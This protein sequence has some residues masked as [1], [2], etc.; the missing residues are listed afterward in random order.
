[1]LIRTARVLALIGALAA[2]AISV[3]PTP[4]GAQEPPPDD[5][6]NILVVVTDDQRVDTMSIMRHTRDLLTERGT[7][8]SHAYA[9]TPLCCPSRS[10]IFSG[11]YVHNHGVDTNGGSG[12]LDQTTTMQAHLQGAGYYTAMAGKFLNGWPVY[13]RPPYFNRYALRQ[14]GSVYTD[15]VWNIQ[16]NIRVRPDYDTQLLGKHTVAFLERFDKRNDERPWFM[17]VAPIAPHLPADPE[18]KY[19]DAYVP[20]WPDTPAMHEEDLSDK[21]L[22]VQESN[23]RADRDIRRVIRKQFRSLLSVDDLVRRI[24]RKLN[25]LGERRRTL[26]LFL[27]DNGYMWRDHGLDRK[28]YAYIPSVQIPMLMSWPKQVPEAAVDDRLV[29]NIDVAP[30]VLDAAG[31]DVGNVMDGRS[32]LDASWTRDR[33]FLEGDQEMDPTWESLLTYDLQYIEWDEPPGIGKVLE[34][35]DLTVDP[36]QLENLFGDANPTNDPPIAG[37]ALQ[38]EEDREC[39]GTTQE[40]GG[41]SPCP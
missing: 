15:A 16:G 22:F 21:P 1:M 34:Y 12:R 35:Y 3:G 25:D 5:R 28:K 31:I 2:L 7:T 11:R 19:A 9:T 8:F 38:L 10:S 20:P 37:L 33:I 17:Y 36:W 13:R 24:I 41:P 30:T 6:P 32:L 26:I 23:Q 39:S 27:S 4:T 40:P 18:G 14:L 29:A